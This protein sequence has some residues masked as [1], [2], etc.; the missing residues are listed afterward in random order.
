MSMWD[1]LTPRNLLDWQRDAALNTMGH[2]ARAFLRDGYP[3]DADRV[4]D[5]MNERRESWRRE[6]EGS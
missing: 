5:E 6:R 2:Q 4:L 3:V 1:H